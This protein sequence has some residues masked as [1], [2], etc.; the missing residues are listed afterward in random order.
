MLETAIGLSVCLKLRRSPDPPT[1]CLEEPQRS[2]CPFPAHGTVM[3]AGAAFTSR[4]P[5]PINPGLCLWQQFRTHINGGPAP[6]SLGIFTKLW[7]HNQGFV[8]D[9][10]E[11]SGAVWS[12]FLEEIHIDMSLW[13]TWLEAE[14]NRNVYL[15]L[16][17]E[18]ALLGFRELKS[19]GHL[20]IL[21]TLKNWANFPFSSSNS[22]TSEK[23]ARC[24]W[25]FL[26]RLIETGHDGHTCMKK[27]HTDQVIMLESKSK[28]TPKNPNP[29]K[30]LEKLTGLISPRVN[31]S[32]RPSNKNFQ[33]FGCSIFINALFC[34]TV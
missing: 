13:P 7:Q 34:F 4:I 19:K 12:V 2:C 17:T 27:T 1:K 28:Q 15:F 23:G 9:R 26:L 21:V 33:E 16:N 10:R 11:L 25:S 24:V 18:A 32:L 3:W 31:V 20:S 6:F 5:K 22:A 30:T 8:P 14:I 29:T